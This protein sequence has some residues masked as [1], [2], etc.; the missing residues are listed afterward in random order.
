MCV[1]VLHSVYDSK[2][3]KDCKEKGSEKDA[4]SVGDL[5]GYVA[6]DLVQAGEVGEEAMDKAAATG[7]VKEAISSE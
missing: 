5:L 4:P 1:C 2:F 3:T 6:E 7:A